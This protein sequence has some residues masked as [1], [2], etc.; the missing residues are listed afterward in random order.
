M[1]M[2]IFSARKNYVSELLEIEEETNGPRT[3]T[4]QKSEV[5]MK[6]LDEKI[7]VLGGKMNEFLP[8]PIALCPHNYINKVVKRTADSVIRPAKFTAKANNNSKINN[9]SKNNT[10]ADFPPK[11]T[12][13]NVPAKEMEQLTLLQPS[14]LQ[15]LTPR[16]S[17]HLSIK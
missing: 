14:T 4:A 1:E 3:E 17:P 15:K 9:N 5:E 8:C 6:S 2:R 11:K 16:T 10:D 13:K 12:S 7:N